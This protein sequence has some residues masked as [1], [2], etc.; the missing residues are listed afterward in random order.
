MRLRFGYAEGLGYS[1]PFLL[2]LAC[3]AS[4]SWAC[5]NRAL[6]Q[7][8]KSKG[9][10]ANGAQAAV[11]LGEKDTKHS[12]IVPI[13]GPPGVS[14]IKQINKRLKRSVGHAGIGA[15]RDVIAPQ[16]SANRENEGNP[17]K[18]G[19]GEPKELVLVE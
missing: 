12:H 15:G 13:P 18:D 8:R 14:R 2:A 3:L 19:E 11:R 7:M 10:Q 6:A 5:S 17:P 9:E 4:H 1:G 16:A